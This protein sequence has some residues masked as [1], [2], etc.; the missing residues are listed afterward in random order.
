[1][2]FNIIAYENNEAWRSKLHKYKTSVEH[3]SGK[4]RINGFQKERRAGK[5]GRQGSFSV[6]IEEKGI[7]W[8]MQVALPIQC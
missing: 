2:R 5:A 6:G 4:I 1:M 7:E 8:E 3:S